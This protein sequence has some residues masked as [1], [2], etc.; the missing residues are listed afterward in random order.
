[1]QFPLFK[2]KRQEEIFNAFYFLGCLSSIL[3]APWG[4]CLNFSCRGEGSTVPHFAAEFP[5]PYGCDLDQAPAC[6]HFSVESARAHT[7]SFGQ[8][9]SSH[10]GNHVD[11]TWFNIKFVLNWLFHFLKI[12]LNQQDEN[13][14]SSV[15]REQLFVSCDSYHIRDILK[16]WFTSPLKQ[17]KRFNMSIISSSSSLPFKR[18]VT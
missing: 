10:D 16:I 6:W 7:M 8:S 14:E 5:F 9:L 17:R 11:D 12:N 2:R 18:L 1:M 3:H 13:L 15:A 4:F